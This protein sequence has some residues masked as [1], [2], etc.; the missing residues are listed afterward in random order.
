M[1]LIKAPVNEHD[2]YH[3]HVY[4]EQ[5]TVNFAAGFCRTAGDLFFLKVGKVHQ[6]T[7]GP[8]PKWSCQIMFSSSDFTRLV[9]WLDANRKGLTILI[10]AVT[11]N[12]LRDHT[13]YAYW[14]GDKVNINIS[15]FEP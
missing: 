8:H 14:L 9:P 12:D 3:A 7:V 15:M 2:Y 13:D 6:R 4:F 10:H 1:S 11:G 5:E